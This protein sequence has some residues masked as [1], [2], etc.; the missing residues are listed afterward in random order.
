M[1]INS[2]A[3][4]SSFTYGPGGNKVGEI[5]DRV[6]EIGNYLA[7]SPIYQSNITNFGS[8]ITLAP[9]APLPTGANVTTG[10]IALSGSGTAF[11]M[12]VFTGA[13]NTSG[14]ATASIGG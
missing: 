2:N 8:L 13:G 3:A 5:T 4:A 7:S 9:I 11:R 1:P 14:W 6:N 10:S 12:Y